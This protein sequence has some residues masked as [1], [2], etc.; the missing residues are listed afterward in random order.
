VECECSCLIQDWKAGSKVGAYVPI[1]STTIHFCPF[2]FQQSKKYQEANY[3]H[4]ITH[5][6][7]DTE[8]YSLGGRR[9]WAKNAEDAWFYN[10]FVQYSAQYHLD[11][12][13]SKF[14]RQFP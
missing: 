4:E 7:S 11:D 2:Y 10:D 5:V 1:G 14:I 6:F 9:P 3:L 8:D 12:F 13:V